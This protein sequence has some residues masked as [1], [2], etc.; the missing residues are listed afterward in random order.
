MT[1]RRPAKESACFGRQT[2]PSGVSLAILHNRLWFYDLTIYK[3]TPSS[4]LTAS[5]SSSNCS[6]QSEVRAAVRWQTPSWS[7]ILSLC[8]GQERT[9]ILQPLMA[10][11]GTH[12]QW[13]APGLNFAPV[14]EA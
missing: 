13:P 5:L 11:P 12:A 14:G 6:N 1:L 3:N 8:Q 4:S 2:L 7:Q 10:L 9:D